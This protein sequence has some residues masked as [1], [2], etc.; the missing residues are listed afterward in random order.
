MR[1]SSD[2]VRNQ[3]EGSMRRVTAALAVLI[4]SA[5]AVTAQ[6]PPPSVDPHPNQPARIWLAAA[7]HPITGVVEQIQRDSLSLRTPELYCGASGCRY[8]VT[9]AY[10]DITRLQVSRTS[11]LRKTAVAA[12]LLVAVISLF[13]P[14]HT[15]VCVE[16]SKPESPWCSVGIAAGALSLG[17]VARWLSRDR[18]VDVPG[19]RPPDR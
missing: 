7:Q 12:G 15:N 17:V 5:P 3:P 6:R 13:E 10:D 18:W 19:A 11:K 16:S 14:L 8:G 4:F 9:V 2:R 1:L